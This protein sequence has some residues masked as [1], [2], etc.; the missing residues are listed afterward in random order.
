MF[1]VMLAPG[2]FIA[3]PRLFVFTVALSRP[4]PRLLYRY[5]RNRRRFEA[6][7]RQWIEE[8]KGM[9][10]REIQEETARLERVLKRI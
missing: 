9:S 10:P 6:H 8:A 4:Y 7:A 5:L 3:H 1:V 2:F